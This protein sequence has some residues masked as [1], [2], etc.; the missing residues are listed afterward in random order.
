MQTDKGK[1]EG[2]G[3][4]GEGNW[5]GVQRGVHFTACEDSGSHA[6]GLSHP[7]HLFLARWGV[8]LRVGTGQAVSSG[9]RQHGWGTMSLWRPACLSILHRPDRWTHKPQGHISKHWTWKQ[10]VRTEADSTRTLALPPSLCCVHLSLLH[11]DSFSLSHSFPIF[12]WFLS[13]CLR[14]S[15][16]SNC[17]LRGGER[18]NRDSCHTPPWLSPPAIHPCSLA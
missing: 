9:Q 14:I 11:W 10:M 8:P 4:A 16:I 17:C 2:P 12:P 15:C 6:K 5:K 18:I 3:R 13:L 7:Q 1:N